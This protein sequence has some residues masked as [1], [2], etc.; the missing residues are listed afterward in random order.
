MTTSSAVTRLLLAGIATLTI[1]GCHRQN[2]L[3]SAAPGLAPT[4]SATG[5]ADAG[6]IDPSRGAS[7]GS[8]SDRRL[9]AGS[10]VTS[11][12]E[13]LFIARFPGLDV[14]RT[15]N[16]GLSMLLRGKEPLVILDGMEA[17]PLAL[18]PLSP[19]EVERIEVL[20]NVSETAIYGS[21]GVNGVV[22]VTTRR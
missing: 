14:Q 17:D 18:V 7:V 13:D 5:S 3:R 20:R 9:P 2:E 21:R 8:A 11:R 4:P 6:A 22:V 12:I 19:S 10:T 15:A 1:A 16:G